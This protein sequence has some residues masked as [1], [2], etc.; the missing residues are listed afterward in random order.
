MDKPLIIFEFSTLLLVAK[1]ALTLAFVTVTAT[2]FKKPKFFLSVIDGV[3]N[4]CLAVL[5]VF[6]GIILASLLISD[7]SHKPSIDRLF[8]VGMIGICASLVLLVY[9]SIT[10]Q[11]IA[12][13]V[14]SSEDVT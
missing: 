9:A 2:A 1:S 5:F 4:L 11:W 3:Q 8:I 12:R 6:C 14:I 13:K 10:C 7:I